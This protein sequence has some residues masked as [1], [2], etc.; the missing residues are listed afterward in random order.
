MN[1]ASLLDQAVKAEGIPITGV[2]VGKVD[3]PSTW[4]IQYAPE[5]TPEDRQRG[6]NLLAG[7]DPLLYEAAE[8]DRIL[9]FRVNTPMVQAM[10][11]AFAPLVGKTVE[12]CTAA[13]KSKLSKG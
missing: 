11:R 7:F 9:N 6:E 4:G 3:D 5:A 13:L 1:I 2:S 10:F 12:E 8:E